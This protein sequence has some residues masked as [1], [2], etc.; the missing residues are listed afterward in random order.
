MCVIIFAWKVHPEYPLI[1]IAN[2]DEFFAR[3]TLVAA[4]WDKDDP[5]RVVFAGR[6]SVRDG[7]WLGVTD[8]GRLATVTNY[9][10]GTDFSGFPKSRGDVTA[11]FLKGTSTAE[12]YLHGLEGKDYGG[13]TVIVGNIVNGEGLWWASNRVEG[14]H[15]I[16]P[17]LHGLANQHV[18]ANNW[19][20]IK[21]GKEKIEGLL[22]DSN[23]SALDEDLLVESLFHILMNDVKAPYEELPDTGIDLELEHALSSI[24]VAVPEWDYGTR[25]S[26]VILGKANGEIRFVER[27]FGA[28][29]T[30]IQQVQ[31]RST[32]HDDD[33]VQPQADTSQR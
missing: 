33:E 30:L 14:V 9:R 17:G 12:E 32:D 27:S 20:K 29:K 1:L 4:R 3:P 23:C 10:D 2:R 6:D 15:Q 8:E 19:P 18:D 22:S 24:F 28:G 11:D 31:H 5:K 13:Y 21:L 7:T 25:E 16:E 26:T